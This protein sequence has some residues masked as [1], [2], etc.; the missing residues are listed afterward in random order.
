V[1]A[2][3]CVGAFAFVHAAVVVKE[4]VRYAASMYR[5]ILLVLLFSLSLSAPASAKVY[6]HTDKDGVVVY[7]DQPADN[8]EE[9]RVPKGS[10]YTAPSIPK[11][12]TPGST[13][14][15]TAAPTPT[16]YD[17]ISI[18]SPSKEQSIRSNSGKLTARAKIVPSQ[19][20]HNHR[21]RWKLDGQ[22]IE[23]VNAPTLNIN[24]V[25]RGSH[26]LQVAILDE[27]SKQ[28]I[29]SDSITF[30]MVRFVIPKPTPA[31]SA[32]PPSSRSK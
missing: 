20:A 10:T 3:T 12:A 29:T 22:T 18:S 9:I 26:T 19:I 13:N 28:L 23:G 17:S 1:N 32:P 30:Y 7:S 2:S 25:D 15:T 6:K 11:A 5:L 21:L 14:G 27:A 8:A 4:Q 31:P 16:H 24:N